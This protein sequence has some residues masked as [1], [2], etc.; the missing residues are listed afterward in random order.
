MKW[1]KEE[2]EMFKTMSNEEIVEKTGRTLKS[3]QMKRYREGIKE[4]PDKIRRPPSAFESKETRIAKIIAL[5]KRL[6]VKLKG[7]D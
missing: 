1:T 6:G 3:V 5:A 4:D 7:E 2:V